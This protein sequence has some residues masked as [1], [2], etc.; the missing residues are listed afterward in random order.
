MTLGKFYLNAKDH[1]FLDDLNIITQSKNAIIV[2]LPG[3]ASNI[4]S[5]Y[6]K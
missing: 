4:N 1:A 6:I 2:I 3:L 5:Y